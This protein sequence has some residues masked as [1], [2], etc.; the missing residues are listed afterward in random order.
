M[1]LELTDDCDGE[2][3][4][5]HLERVC[6]L[7]KDKSRTMIQFDNDDTVRARESY[8][9]IRDFIEKKYDSVYRLGGK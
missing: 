5:I 8:E 7:I 3:M 1:F 9:S 6:A 2:P 4:L